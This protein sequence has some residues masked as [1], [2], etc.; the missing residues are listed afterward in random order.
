[1]FG[2]IIIYVINAPLLIKLRFAYI[3]MSNINFGGT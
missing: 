2:F 1:M 3:N